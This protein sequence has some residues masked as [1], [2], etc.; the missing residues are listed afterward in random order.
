MFLFGILCSFLLWIVSIL[1]RNDDCVLWICTQRNLNS[2]YFVHFN[3]VLCFCL[4]CLCSFLFEIISNLLMNDDCLLWVLSVIVYKSEFCTLSIV[5]FCKLVCYLICM[6]NDNEV[7]FS[8]FSLPYFNFVWN[9][10]VV[11]R[12]LVAFLYVCYASVVV[13]WLGASVDLCNCAYVFIIL[14]HSRLMY[15]LSFCSI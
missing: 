5:R 11:Y 4:G 3:V 2:Q 14:R 7:K 6:D 13:Q 9:S 12:P 10:H 8:F 1:L 15:F